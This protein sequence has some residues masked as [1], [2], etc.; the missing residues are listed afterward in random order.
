MK[1]SENKSE[2]L[3]A[4]DV[5]RD[6]VFAT[7]TDLSFWKSFLKTSI[8][9][10]KVNNPN[11]VE[12]YDAGFYVYEYGLDSSNGFLKGH[13]EIRS[14]DTSNLERYKDDFV[15]WVS[16]LTVLKVY[17][18]LENFVLQAI[19]I[20]YFPS[21]N[22]TG[23]RKSINHINKAII[24]YLKNED[25]NDDT[26]NNRHIIRFLINKSPNINLFLNQSM[27]IDLITNWGNFF[28]LISIL[29]NV[30]AHQGT[31]INIDTQ[32]EIKS[33]AKDVFQRY[34]LIKK[35]EM[36]NQHLQPNNEQYS[37]F[38]S[39]FNTFSLHLVQCMFDE[40]DLKFLEMN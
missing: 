16:N 3:K 17:N 36:G 4:F 10:Y 13:K 39:Y 33:K 21:I 30:I 27:N 23:S 32:N 2:I 34:F 22:F 9:D 11:Q 1:T 29:R 15:S 12:L 25:M 40:N 26:T 38:I 35:D 37:G 6:I 5:Y 28:E 24:T 31:V 14:I 19:Q 7:A 8:N 18:A 20:K